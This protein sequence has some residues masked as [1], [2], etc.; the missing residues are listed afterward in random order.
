MG[1]HRGSLHQR[2][3]PAGIQQPEDPAGGGGSRL[4]GKLRGKRR[5]RGRPLVQAP[6]L[7]QEGDFRFRLRHRP[8]LP[9]QARQVLPV[10]PAGPAP[11]GH[12]GAV[13]GDRVPGV[14]LGPPRPLLHR[15]GSPQDG[16]GEG[17]GG[18]K[19]PAEVAGEHQREVWRGKPFRGFF[20]AERVRRPQ[21]GIRSG[22]GPGRLGQ[23]PRVSGPHHEQE[24]HP[25]CGV[26]DDRHGRRLL[27]EEL[28]VQGGTGDADDLHQGGALQGLDRSGDEGRRGEEGL[29][30]N[31][32]DGGV[33]V[34]SCGLVGVF[35]CCLLSV[36]FQNAFKPA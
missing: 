14:G 23:R 32:E 20:R 12:Q 31:G 29:R 33:G 25:R 5:N 8:R 18:G 17:A 1:P 27:R 28:Q 10:R 26:D 35:R 13:G 22:G 4:R 2:A 3:P 7:R 19:V 24:G 9:E 34:G 36:N 15:V 16:K 11:A 30:G 6:G 21:Q